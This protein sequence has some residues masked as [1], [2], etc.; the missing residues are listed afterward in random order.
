MN[1]NVLI[2]DDEPLGA[3]RIKRLLQNDP[4]LKTIAVAESAEGAL[5]LLRESAPDILFLDIELPEMNGFELLE[6]LRPGKVPY[7]IF[8]T[9]YEEHA[10]HAFEVQAIDYLLK[11]VTRQRLAGSLQRAKDLFRNRPAANT[12]YATRLIVKERDGVHIVKTSDIDWIEADRRYVI[13]HAGL[14]TFVMREAISELALRLDPARFV[15]VHRSHIVNVDRIAKLQPLFR[16]EYRVV[17]QNGTNLLLTRHY[18]KF[19]QEALGDKS[20]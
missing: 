11:P 20:L 15:R 5:E 19:V 6:K 14:K 17:L 4:D 18:K 12:Q 7:V 16:G 8:V 13:L 3:A 2:V 9:A 1:L 10:I